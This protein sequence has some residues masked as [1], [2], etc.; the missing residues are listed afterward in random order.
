M[1]L[2]PVAIPGNVLA[3]LLEV[4]RRLDDLV[5][6]AAMPTVDPEAGDGE[7]TYVE[8]LQ[9]IQAGPDVVVTSTSTDVTVGRAGDSILLF[10]PGAVLR[11]YAFTATGLDSALAAAGA[12]DVIWLPPGSCPGDHSIPDGVTVAGL[13]SL[14]AVLTGQ[15]TLGNNGLGADDP[16]GLSDVRVNRTANDG[17]TLKGVIAPATGG[18]RI[19]RT[20]VSCVQAGVGASYA[21]SVE[22]AGDLEVFASMLYASSGGGAAWGGYRVGAANLYVLNSIIPMDAPFNE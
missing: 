11:E 7:V 18:C 13:S 12:G 19:V 5:G 8:I 22:D 1:S 2:D 17:N 16:P 15:I 21:V 10:T 3:R 9:D 4:E 6:Y 14:T 20:F